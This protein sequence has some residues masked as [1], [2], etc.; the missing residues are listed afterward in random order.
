[1]TKKEILDYVMH[2]PYNT[3][4][5]VLSGMLDGLDATGESDLEKIV[6]YGSFKELADSII[7]TPEIYPQVEST[8]YIIRG[9]N[10]IGIS[11]GG[12]A[13]LNQNFYRV[14]EGEQDELIF[15]PVKESSD[16][17]EE[18]S[19]STVIHYWPYHNQWIWSSED[20]L[21]HSTDSTLTVQRLK[22]KMDYITSVSLENTLTNK[23]SVSVTSVEI[24]SETYNWSNFCVAFNNNELS[25]TSEITL[26]GSP[27]ESGSFQFNPDICFYGMKKETGQPT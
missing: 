5:A 7:F 6:I 17:S 1:M 22:N 18:V 19:L 12:A 26:Y 25:E 23:V 27:A 2:T 20:S 11:S 3:N 13:I 8:F 16:P 10:Y 9:T 21:Y 4:R 24:E 14:E 15:T